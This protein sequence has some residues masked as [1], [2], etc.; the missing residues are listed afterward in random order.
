MP[1]ALHVVSMRLS[2]ISKELA[3]FDSGGPESPT[4]GELNQHRLEVLTKAIKEFLVYFDGV[5]LIKEAAR[6]AADLAQT[7]RPP[8]HQQGQALA[9]DWSQILAKQP[10][11]YLKMTWTVDL[12]ISKGRLPEEPDFP[13]WLS[14][15]LRLVKSYNPGWQLQSAS[16][17][18]ETP[19]LTFF[20]GSI[21]PG[22][23][24]FTDF[25]TFPN[26]FDLTGRGQPKGDGSFNI[27]AEIAGDTAMLSAQDERPQGR[28]INMTA[29][30][31]FSMLD[32][33]GMKWSFPN[34][35]VAPGFLNGQDV[36]FDGSRGPE[37]AG[38]DDVP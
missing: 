1:L 6:H 27:M 19:D 35:W 4:T 38:E 24:S 21:H 13:D 30:E 7:D 29:S 28:D 37:Q 9:T 32:L 3:L 20:S 16:S 31:R 11:K 12:Y 8:V 17:D 33:D 15:K 36:V 5:E 2:S 10:A 14:N 18:T 22:V 25:I 26:E 23:G 34:E